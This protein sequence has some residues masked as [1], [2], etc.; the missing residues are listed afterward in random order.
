[1]AGFSN[2]DLFRRQIGIEL[3]YGFLYLEPPVCFVGKLGVQLLHAIYTIWLQC[4]FF[5]LGLGRIV[6]HERE[7]ERDGERE[8]I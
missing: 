7:R 2:H 1:M 6:V 3:P 4:G 5:V 8:R